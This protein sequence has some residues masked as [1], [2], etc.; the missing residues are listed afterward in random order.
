MATK[1]I[2]FIVSPTGKFQLAYN[3]GETGTFDSKQADE[4]IELGYAKEVGKKDVDSDKAAADKAAA[5]KAAADK[6]A[7]D[8]AAADKAAADKAAADKAAA[9][10]IKPTEN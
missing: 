6:A 10:V 4:L 2:K 1:K 3:V 7:A 8:K 9:D 5:D